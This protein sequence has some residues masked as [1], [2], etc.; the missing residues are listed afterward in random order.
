DI[1]FK[2]R[3][4]LENG[5]SPFKER[6]AIL[7]EHGEIPL[8][9]YIRKTLSDES[10]YQT[11]YADR[12]GSSAAPTAGLHFTPEIFS[13]IEKKGVSVRRLTLHVGL[14]TFLPF[15]GED[16][17]RDHL[18]SESYEIPEATAAALQKARLEKWRVIAVGTTSLRALEDS[19]RRSGEF[20]AGWESTRLFIRPPQKVVSADALITNFH[21]PE[22]SLLMLVAA[23]GGYDRVFAAYREAVKERYRFFSLGDAM[24]IC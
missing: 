11:V 2:V 20:R 3:R 16:R 10:R 12:F 24:F 6:H 8:P 4:V 17:T 19:V 22:S 5:D 7:Q 18:H 9:P 14:G 13:A 1:S 21:L 15:Y 23:F